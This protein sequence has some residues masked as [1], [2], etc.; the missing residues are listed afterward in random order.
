MS[1]V[2]C[3]YSRSRGMFLPDL[4]VALS[5]D[6]KYKCHFFD[7]AMPLLSGSQSCSEEDMGDHCPGGI[8][9]EEEFVPG[10]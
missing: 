3:G 9:K 4:P 10:K 1:H 6:L 2:G 5:V 7:D 8:S